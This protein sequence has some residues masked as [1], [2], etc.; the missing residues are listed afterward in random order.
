MLSRPPARRAPRYAR[1]VADLRVTVRLSGP[2]AER[3]GP[4]RRVEL[5][6]GARVRDLVD[7]LG[8]EAGLEDGAAASLAVV[9]QGTI[10]PHGH[11]LADGDELDVLAPVAG[12]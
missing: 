10:V 5:P 4:R 9:R 6:Q 2:L 12:G 7:A 3:L 11:A 8:R 1:P